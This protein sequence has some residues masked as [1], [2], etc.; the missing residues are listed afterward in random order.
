MKDLI[1]FILTSYR[2]L[3]RVSLFADYEQI[4]NEDLQPL[5]K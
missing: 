2:K 5:D 3:L 4:F 1:P